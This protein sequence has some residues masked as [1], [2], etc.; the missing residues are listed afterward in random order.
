MG[1]MEDNHLKMIARD[2]RSEGV[3]NRSR[4]KKR[5]NESLVKD[6]PP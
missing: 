5:W 2:S 1:R 3:R 6:N 4:T